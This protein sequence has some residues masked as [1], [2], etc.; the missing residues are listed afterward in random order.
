MKTM[1]YLVLILSLL[2]VAP[3]FGQRKKKDED[4]VIVP[5]FVEGIAYALPRTGIRVYVTVLNEKYL[6]GPYRNYAKQLL[7]ISDAPA[8]NSSKYHIS[9]LRIETFSEP[10]PNRAYKAMGDVAYFLNLTA[11]GRLAGINSNKEITLENKTLTNQ[12]IG[13][14]EKKDGFSFE[15]FTDT[16]FYTEGDST[17]N[18]RPVPVSVEQKAAEA[19]QRIL[20][21]RLNI[22][23]M[24]AG[25][26]DEFHPDGKA[27]EISMN[28][29]KKIENNYLSL[30]IGRTTYK[31]EQFVFDLIPEKAGGKGTVLFRVS[32]EKGVVPAT[33]LSGKPVLVE[34]ETENTL[35]GKYAELAKSE[36]PNAGES[37]VYFQLPGMASVKV[38]YELQTIATARIT[39][40]QFGVVAPLPEDLLNGEFSIEIHPETGAIKSVSLK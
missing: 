14:P 2:I 37:G 27:Y 16:P 13:K 1:K 19:A 5:T 7:G 21:C 28:E 17:N 34:F 26:Y 23:D 40:A 4:V 9:D 20:E 8:Q 32:D 12:F 11:D 6:A 35:A 33:D 24:A 18:F 29:L 30:F 15:N 38:I 25:M 36:N 3:S 31:K 22:Y 10:N 39:V